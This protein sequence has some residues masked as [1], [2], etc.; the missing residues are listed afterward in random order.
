[1]GCDVGGHASGMET[2]QGAWGL[3]GERRQART[4]PSRAGLDRWAKSGLVLLG[5][6]VR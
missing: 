3:A 2:M 5:S 6:S 4:G 1:M